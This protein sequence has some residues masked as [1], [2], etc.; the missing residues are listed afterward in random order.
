MKNINKFYSLLLSAVFIFITISCEEEDRDTDFLNDVAIPSN[1]TLLLEVTQDNTG[2]VTFTPAGQSAASFLIE[3]GDD[4]EPQTVLPG[5]TTTHVYGEG[6]FVA[7][8]TA[9]NINGDSSSITQD[10][11]ISFAPPQNL[12][13]TITPVPGDNFSIELSATAELATGFE[14]FFGDVAEETPTPL[15]VGSTIQHTYA[16]TGTFEVRVVALSGGEATIEETVLVTIENPILLPID[17]ESETLEYTFIDFGGATSTLVDNPD[18]TGENTSNT[19]ASFFKAAGAETFAGSVIELGEVIDFSGSPVFTLKTWSPEVGATVRLKLENGTDVDVF[20][21]IDAVT[22]VA[23][24]WETLSFDFTGFTDQE[25]SKVIVFFDFG[26]PGAGTTYFYDDIAQFS[27]EIELPITFEL[28]EGAYTFFGFEGADS[29]IEMNPDMSGVN[30]SATV[31]RSIKTNGS[32]FFAGT[33]LDLDNAIET[34]VASV[35]SVDTWSPKANIPIR[36]AIENQDAGNQIFVDANTTVTDAW[37]TL[38]FDFS[39]LVDSA[40]DYNRIVIFFE[41]IVDLPGDGS[42]YYFDNIELVN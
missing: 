42:T 4:S 30:T 26:N 9:T 25:Y 18:P 13:V 36:L 2:T 24:S 15:M 39:T 33:F 17:F 8:L 10:V 31:M 16:Q 23:N 5:D 22:T 3:F 19:V 14:V 7:T 21:E 6:A 38:T 32:Q 35:I 37:E 28:P 12:Q 29:A 11:I 20:T 34:N 41:F 1:L 40:I 27:N